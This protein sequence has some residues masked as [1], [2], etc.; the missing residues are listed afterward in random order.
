MTSTIRL[1]AHA[2]IDHAE[3]HGLTLSKYADPTE[4]AR[5]GLSVD[6]A[7]AVAREDAG[8]IYLDAAQAALA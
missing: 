2:A 7:R 1:E 6:E 5:E 8:L 3:A 4:G